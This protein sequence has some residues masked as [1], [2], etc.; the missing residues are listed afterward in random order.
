MTDSVQGDPPD[1][2]QVLGDVPCGR[3]HLHQVHTGQ[4]KDWLVCFYLLLVLH[5]TYAGLGSHQ[6]HEALSHISSSSSSS[7][8]KAACLGKIHEVLP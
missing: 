3:F 4:P 1:G 5:I 7:C 6:A 2:R 8:A